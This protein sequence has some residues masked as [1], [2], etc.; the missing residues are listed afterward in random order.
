MFVSVLSYRF[1]L[2]CSFFLA[3]LLGANHAVWV[4]TNTS[5][6]ETVNFQKYYS[7]FPD[8]YAQS[9][10]IATQKSHC[11]PIEM[12]D[13]SHGA[14][15]DWLSRSFVVQPYFDTTGFCLAIDSLSSNDVLFLGESLAPFVTRLAMK[16]GAEHCSDTCS[17]NGQCT[18]CICNREHKM[19]YAKT[20]SSI[21]VISSTDK[22]AIIVVSRGDEWPVVEQE[23]NSM[24][25][26][27]S[28]MAE[29]AI[30]LPHLFLVNKGQ[31]QCAVDTATTI[32]PDIRQGGEVSTLLSMHGAVIAINGSISSNNRDTEA[33]VSFNEAALYIFLSHRLG[34]YGSTCSTSLLNKLVPGSSGNYTTACACAEIATICSPE[35]LLDLFSRTLYSTVLHNFN[36]ANFLFPR[37]Q[38]EVKYLLKNLEEGAA[39]EFS[40]VELYH[41]ALHRAAA[42][43]LSV[44]NFL[45]GRK[46]LQEIFSLKKLASKPDRRVGL[47]DHSHIAVLSMANIA[48][49][50]AFESFYNVTSI[51]NKRSFI[52]AIDLMTC[53]YLNNRNMPHLC[54]LQTVSGER[55]F[56]SV[57]PPIMFTVG[58]SKIWFPLV[59]ASLNIS[60]IFSEM[61]IFWQHDP[62]ERDL[63]SYE[64]IE[65][66]FQV[67]GHVD[68]WP[69]VY[70]LP[71]EINIGF[72]YLRPSASAITFFTDMLLYST[73]HSRLFSEL[74]TFDQKLFDNF[75]RWNLKTEEKPK[76]REHFQQ[77]AHF[78]S[79]NVEFKW[80]RLPGLLYLHN[81][82]DQLCFNKE[83]IT[84]HISWGIST[85][86]KR[87]Y[88][89][90]TLGLM[91]I[92][93]E[94]LTQVY[95]NKCCFCGKAHSCAGMD[96]LIIGG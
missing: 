1:I 57:A 43:E 91:P 68:F 75:L 8:W 78:A 82:G 58:L 56:H 42:F 44:V 49:S 67:T 3:I 69:I 12:M 4:P 83:V 16:M 36:G 41:S 5:Y 20:L 53:D 71:S 89:A 80:R 55:A 32:S 52:I 59:F 34:E 23:E 77:I 86:S 72:F 9:A 70:A 35:L 61:D 27:L 11:R 10:M 14:D 54:V 79:E 13:A 28:K 85:P 88:C 19:T 33:W 47:K 90:H 24:L 40:V 46:K 50:D 95:E 17:T 39:E 60:C 81:Q 74:Y 21:G 64:N 73:M 94:H 2:N 37:S 30:L 25:N 22:F 51:N 29:I 93:N 63:D 7:Y 66:D 48:Y 6:V 96:N 92:Y 84:V 87:V 15:F 18:Y 45:H 26:G 65:F 62:V 31:T 76:W 38:S